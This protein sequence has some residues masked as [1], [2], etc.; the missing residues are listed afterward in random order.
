MES[1][2]PKIHQVWMMTQ[3]ELPP[4]EEQIRPN[5]SITFLTLHSLPALARPGTFDSIFSM[6][7]RRFM[8]ALAVAP[9]VPALI[10]QQPAVPPVGGAVPGASGGRA[11]RGGRGG[12]G[13]GTGPALVELTPPDA[14]AETRARF[15]TPA[16]FNALK[17]LADTLMPPMRGNLGALDCKAPEFLDF[18][19]SESPA[20]RKLLYRA[21]LDSLNAKATAKY[22][23]PFAD[24]DAKQVDAVIRPLLTAMPWSHDAPKDPDKHFLAAAHDDIR[25]ATRNSPEWAAAGGT[26]GRGGRGGRG[27]GAGGGAGVQIW[28]PIDP[29]YKG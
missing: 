22:A 18:L 28:L 4:P 3:K 23:K 9:A 8:Q 19:V 11:G 1:F 6:K 2:G 10:A 14:V 29:L 7:R 20:D 27:G 17:K 26:G 12:F 15:F 13:G 5:P 24:L 25:T 21:G 16:Q